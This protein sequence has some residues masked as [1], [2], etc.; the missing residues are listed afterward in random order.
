MKLMKNALTEKH[1]ERPEVPL[2]NCIYVR[3][4][5]VH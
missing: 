4:H 2:P 5:L 3:H 1:P